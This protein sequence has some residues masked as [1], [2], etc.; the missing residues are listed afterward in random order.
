MSDEPPIQVLMVEDDA[1]L[2][3]LSSRYLEGNG[4]AVTLCETGPHALAETQ[5]RAFDL[6][7]L[8]LMLPGLDGIEVCRELRKR[9][10]VPIIMITARREEADRVLGLD[11]GADDYVTKPFSS[12]ELV[13]RIRAVV[14]RARGLVGP[15]A[16]TLK[17]GALTIDLGT[18]RVRMGSK[19]LALT[20]NEFE[21]LRLLAERGGRVLTRDQLLDAMGDKGEDAFARSIDIHVCRLRNKLGDDARQPRLL[22]TVRGIGYQLDSREDG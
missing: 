8:D 19:D 22:K 16:S 6:V 9:S 12:R 10:D 20:S 1:R 7:L 13:S 17:V 15:R 2:A 5:R 4:F 3:G 21:I 18:R 11:A 14:R